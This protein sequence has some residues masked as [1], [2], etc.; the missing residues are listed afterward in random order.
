MWI[1]GPYRNDPMNDPSRVAAV[2]PA[3]MAST[4]LPGKPLL[5]IQGLPMI[6]HVRRRANLCRSFS[7]VVV[8]T[9]DREIADVVRR[10]GGEVR[11]TS[12][13]HPAATD[14][15][16]EAAEQLNCSH[17]VNVQGDEILVLPEDL[18]RMVKAI[19]TQPELPAWNAVAQLEN[20]REI[21]DRSV[22]K[23][24]V[25]NSGRI[26]ICSR[27]F[28]HLPLSAEEGFAPV[29]RILGVLA[30]RKDFLKRYGTL[31]R[32]PL[33]RAESIDQNRILEHDVPLETIPFTRGY[34]G[35]NEVRELEDVR[36]HL[37]QD[38]LQ[39]AVL[40]EVLIQ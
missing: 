28:S 3:R 15:V 2:I 11:M 5:E 33:E 40:Q 8:A 20:S 25:S 7:E 1:A 6:E 29:R 26:L 18:E 30:Y 32:T 14:R 9:C 36:H 17:V 35:V 27:D 16:A 34:T 22:V 24:A 23:C 13:R 31:A 4:R 10:H 39:Q 19:Q 12:S 37:E 38:T 21:Q